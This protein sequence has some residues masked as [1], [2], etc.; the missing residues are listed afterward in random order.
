MACFAPVLGSA[1]DHHTA[2]RGHFFM[3]AKLCPLGLPLPWLRTAFSSLHKGAPEMDKALRLSVPCANHQPFA[4]RRSRRRWEFYSLLLLLRCAAC[5][6]IL[7]R[8]LQAELLL[9]RPRGE[10]MFPA[11]VFDEHGNPQATM[12]HGQKERA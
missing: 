7:K 9:H 11:I 8:L 4:E 6:S 2:L 10:Q 5:G 1:L 12:T 3:N